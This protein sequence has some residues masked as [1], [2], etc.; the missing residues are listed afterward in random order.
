MLV[1][2]LVLLTVAPV[3]L[4]NNVNPLIVYDFPAK[5]IVDGLIAVLLY[6]AVMLV[7][8]ALV[9]VPLFNVT[10]YVFEVHT[11]YNAVFPVGVK[12]PPLAY[13]IVVPVLLVVHPHV[14]PSFVMVGNVFDGISPNCAYN[15]AA[16]SFI[17]FLFASV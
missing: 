14:Y 16:P 1:N 15:V 5:V 4:S 6:V 13:I 3:A 7:V 8:P 11:P 9:P 17:H 12:L 10:V 2:V